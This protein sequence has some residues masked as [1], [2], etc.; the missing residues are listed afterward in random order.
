MCIWPPGPHHFP[1][2]ASWDV[3]PRVTGLGT[4][5][6]V[7]PHFAYVLVGANHVTGWGCEQRKHRHRP[8]LKALRLRTVGGRGQGV[9]AAGLLLFFCQGHVSWVPQ[10]EQRRFTAWFVSYRRFDWVVFPM[11]VPSWHIHISHHPWGLTG[12]CGRALTTQEKPPRGPLFL[13]ESP[14]GPATGIIQPGSMCSTLISVQSPGFAS[15]CVYG[16]TSQ[17][18]QW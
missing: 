2:G 12:G 6:D 1:C 7:R 15:G 18:A 5:V 16:P 8:G 11:S 3:R 10:S 14:G 4:G 13:L 9:S 17:V